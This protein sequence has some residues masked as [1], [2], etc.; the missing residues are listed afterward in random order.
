MQKRQSEILKFRIHQV[1]AD[2][3]PFIIQK[4]FTFMITIMQRTLPSFLIPERVSTVF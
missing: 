2:S 3:Y 4:A 1:K